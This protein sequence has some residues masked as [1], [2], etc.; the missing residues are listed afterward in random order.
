[1]RFIQTLK[2]KQ[3]DPSWQLTHRVV[4]VEMS[5]LEVKFVGDGDVLEHIVDKQEGMDCVSVPEQVCP[6]GVSDPQFAPPGVQSSS[7]SVQRMVK[8]KNPAG[9]RGCRQEAELHPD[10][11][12]ALDEQNYVQAL[13]TENAEGIPHICSVTTDW[14]WFS[15]ST[16]SQTAGNTWAWTQ[17]K[18]N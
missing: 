7:G 9:P 12:G 5:V 18:S 17:T 10:E 4:L 1:M 14:F 15:Q 6:L 2:T 8:F 16:F 11:G 13:G 3:K